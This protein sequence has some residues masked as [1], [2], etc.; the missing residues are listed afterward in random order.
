MTYRELCDDTRK[1]LHEI[2]DRPGYIEAAQLH[3]MIDNYM[4][5]AEDAEDEKSMSMPIEERLMDMIFTFN[6]M[7]ADYK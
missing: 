1:K 2:A 5:D 7:E 4:D 3:K 6:I